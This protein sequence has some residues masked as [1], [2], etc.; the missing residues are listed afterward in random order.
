MRLTNV[1][2]RQH[3]GWHSKMQ[4]RTNK[5]RNIENHRAVDNLRAMGLP[6]IDPL[7][8]FIP[9]P[10][11][12]NVPCVNSKTI[13]FILRKITNFS[14]VFRVELVEPT[15]ITEHA[16]DET[17]PWWNSRVCHMFGDSNVLIFGQKQ[18]QT[19]TKTLQFN[20]L[21][22]RIQELADNTQIT[23]ETDIQ[24]KNSILQ[25]HLYETHLE[26]LKIRKHPVKKMW[27]F[28]RDYGLT[29][30]RKKYSLLTFHNDT[31]NRIFL[32]NLLFFKFQSLYYRQN[33][34]AM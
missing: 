18:A 28:P 15:P 4:W 13:K 22:K 11:M 21:P 16:R 7:E 17:H 1:V 31:T 23:N 29:D 2:F 30:Q 27:V 5:H 32:L 19:L 20:E 10:K 9:K 6:V 25:A 33:F 24:F 3:L 12:P 14:F 8:E 34:T 26:K